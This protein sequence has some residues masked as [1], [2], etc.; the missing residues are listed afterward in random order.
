VSTL[1]PVRHE[2]ISK[3]IHGFVHLRFCIRKMKSK[4][5]GEFFGQSQR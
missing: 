4:P 1:H 3:G 5:T 2:A